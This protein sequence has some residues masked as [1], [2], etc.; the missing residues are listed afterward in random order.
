MLWKPRVHAQTTGNR[1]PSC[2]PRECPQTA[3]SAQSWPVLTTSATYYRRCHI[4]KQRATFTGGIH[5]VPLCHTLAVHPSMLHTPNQE[6]EQPTLAKLSRINHKTFQ[7]E[8]PYMKHMLWAEPPE[9]SGILRALPPGSP[10]R[11]ILNPE[12]KRERSHAH[13][14]VRYESGNAP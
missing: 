14:H 8:L 2:S 13:T 11:E 7:G 1:R 12:Q 4:S 9:R 5:V 3:R 6:Q 10:C